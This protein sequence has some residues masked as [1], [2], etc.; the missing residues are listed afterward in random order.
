MRF[1]A[2]TQKLSGWCLFF[3]LVCW[4]VW[5]GRKTLK[6]PDPSYHSDALF[7]T[8]EVCWI[9]RGDPINRDSQNILEIT[10]AD[11]FDDQVRFGIAQG[12]SFLQHRQPKT[13]LESSD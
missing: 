11:M 2:L 5:L 12:P 8:L 7:P 4:S 9:K 6:R 3:M 1:D 13:H 10:D